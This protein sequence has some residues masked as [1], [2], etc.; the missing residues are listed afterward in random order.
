MKG[1]RCKQND[2]PKAVVVAHTGK[3]GARY[4]MMMM[5]AAEVQTIITEEV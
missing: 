5:V 4:E 3:A 2:R 1:K